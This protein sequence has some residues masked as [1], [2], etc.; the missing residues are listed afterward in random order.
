MKKFTC[1]LLPVCIALSGMIC[2]CSQVASPKIH[3]LQVEGV[4]WACNMTTSYGMLGSISEIEGE[5]RVTLTASD[6]DLLY[7]NRDDLEFYYR[8]SLKDGSDLEVT[9]DTLY[10]VSVYLNGKLNYMELAESSSPEA[11]EG[12]SDTEISQ[13]STLYLKGPLTYDLLSMLEQHESQLQGIGLVL[14]NGSGSPNLTDLLSICRP[15]FLVLDDSW[16]LPE[17][18]DNIILDGLELLAI[19][20][21]VSALS[22][23]APYCRNL[24]SLIVS[25]WEPQQGELLQLSSLKKLKNLTLAESYLT[26]LQNIE[27][28]ESLFSLNLIFCDTLG[29]IAQVQKLPELW[30]LNLTACDEVNNVGMLKN[31]ESLRWISFPVNITQ[32][33]FHELAGSL[34]QLEVAE[35]IDC[36]EITDLSPLRQMEHLKVLALYLEKEQFAGLDSLTQL[37]LLIL[38]NELFKDNP[39]LVKELRASL[40]QCNIVPGSGLCLGSGWLLLLLPLILLFRYSFRRKV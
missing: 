21:E 4:T 20:G 19:Q 34:K 14:D 2:G 40:P 23:F 1:F 27:F 39:E 18:G 37:E 29:D 32:K 12:L 5:N 13:L 10:A 38:T 25:G 36:A 26:S 22:K 31:L 24:E 28:P 35:L 16:P 17:P 8:Y 30:R 33:E 3:I 9:F 15:E 6:G 7:M 11:F